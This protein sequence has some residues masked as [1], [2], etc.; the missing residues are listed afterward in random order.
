MKSGDPPAGRKG[1]Q[2]LEIKRLK[3]GRAGIT[4]DLRGEAACPFPITASGSAL[5]KREPPRLR[6]LPD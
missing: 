4:A 2:R 3:E 6:K 1:R 5:R